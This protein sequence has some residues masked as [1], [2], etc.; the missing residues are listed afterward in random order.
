M[1]AGYMALSSGVSFNWVAFDVGP[2]LQGRYSLIV[3]REYSLYLLRGLAYPA[4]L[5]S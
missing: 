3:S 1:M 2:L 5:S 4:V